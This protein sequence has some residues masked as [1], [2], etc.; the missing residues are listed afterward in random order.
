MA[1][2]NPN[3]RPYNRENWFSRLLARKGQDYISSGKL[4]DGEVSGNVERII[5]DIVKGRIDYDVYGNYIL[6]PVVFDNLLSY[7]RNKVAMTSAMKYALEYVIWSCEMGRIIIANTTINPTMIPE[8]PSNYCPP[9]DYDISLLNKGLSTITPAM[10]N[11]IMV[12]MRDVSLDYTKFSILCNTLDRAQST[13]N[14][15]ELQWI[16][17]NLKQYITSNNKLMY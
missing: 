14:I 13:K 4:T 11:T 5:D 10:K 3:Q 1:Y 12:T 6:M 17:G 16:V 15:Y 2:N 9:Y 7:C 8:N